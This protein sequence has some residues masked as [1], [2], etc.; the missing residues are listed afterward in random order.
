[1]DAVP[2]A[3]VP[4]GANIFMTVI[5]LMQALNYDEILKVESKYR[6]LDTFSDEPVEDAMCI[7]FHAFFLCEF[8]R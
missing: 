6:H 5:P 8:K 2:T 4:A 7:F 1:L 3:A